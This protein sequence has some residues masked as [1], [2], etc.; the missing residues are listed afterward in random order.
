VL[1]QR[2]VSI[3]GKTDPGA[4]VTVNGEGVH[5]LGDGRFQKLV[6]LPEGDTAVRVRVRSTAGL[7]TERSVPVPVRVF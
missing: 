6:E 4:T 7:L 2:L 3:S 5:V 1:S